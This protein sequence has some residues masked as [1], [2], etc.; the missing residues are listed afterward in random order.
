MKKYLK[1]IEKD[2]IYNNVKSI[3]IDNHIYIISR[4]VLDRAMQILIN[5]N[6]CIDT[7][8]MS[9][10]VKTGKIAYFTHKSDTE[11]E[12]KAY[13]N[14]TDKDLFLLQW[15]FKPEIL[16]EVAMIKREYDR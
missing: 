3:D 14:S 6:M 12:A 8:D 15:Y 1:D 10:N 7:K 9:T 5:Q 11:K 2:L 13:K 4:N 16:N